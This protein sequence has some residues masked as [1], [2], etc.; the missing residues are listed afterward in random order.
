MSNYRVGIDCRLAGQQHAGIGRYT[1]ELVKRVTA[2][3][4]IDWVL[5]Y[6][7][8]NQI[9]QIFPDS[10]IPNN[11]TLIHAPIQHYTLQEQ[12]KMNAIFTKASLDLLHV[13]HF[14]IPIFYSRPLVITI[15]DLLW[16]E[17]RG[18]EVTTLPAWKYW[19]K[20]WF[21]RL[22]TRIAIQKSLTIFVPTNTVRSTLKKYF[23]E[24]FSKV[25]VTPEGISDHL[26]IQAKKL[27]NLTR[28]SNKLLYVGSL[29][30]HKN[31]S[32]VIKALKL[33][34]DHTLTIVSSRSVF[35]KKLQKEVSK[36][37]LDKRVEFLSNVDDTQLARL[38]KTSATLIQPSLSEGFGLTGLEAITF[39]TPVIASNI[40][41]F[42]EVYRGA[43]L[44][45]DPHSQ[46]DFC[47][48]IAKL[49]DQ[50][51]LKN[52]AN[53]APA[54]IKKNDWD[55]LSNRTYLSYQRILNT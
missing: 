53:S 27:K 38:Y 48:A 55:D 51:K 24:S 19:I 14:N 16:H 41:V 17:H 12:F 18:A 6:S 50:E 28:I 49:S 1:V 47:K 44:Y 42:K 7:E 9:V 35:R 46:E 22:V 37:E 10:E 8:T 43:A 23:P 2:H 45:F 36:Y 54:V 26:K 15:H 20:Y 31:V 13:P 40:P 32:L 52:L 21:Y 39:S 11:C 5:F 3:K 25:V 34:P 29:Y 33:L 4:K 30:P